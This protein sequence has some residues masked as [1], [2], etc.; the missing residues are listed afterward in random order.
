ML[1]N[2]AKKEYREYHLSEEERGYF[3]GLAA[4][5]SNPK[6]HGQDR[7]SVLAGESS[8]IYVWDYYK[9]KTVKKEELTVVLELVGKDNW[10]REVYKD[11]YR[12]LWKNVVFKGID[13][14]SSY[15][16]EFYGEPDESI[17]V[18][19]IILEN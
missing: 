13:L 6:M 2:G 17:K 10:N 1:R 12:K 4:D 15:N 11:Q 5:N 19:F 8:G 3:E 16:N 9:Q 7:Y 18:P 14:Y